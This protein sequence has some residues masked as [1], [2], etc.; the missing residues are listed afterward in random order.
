MNIEKIMTAYPAMTDIH[1]TEGETVSIRVY[2]G[3]KK[4]KET[5]DNDFFASLFHDFLGAEKEEEWE[6]RGSCDGGGTIGSCRLRIHL[7]HS[8]GRKAA[9]LRI[10]PSLA[11]LS[12]DPDREWIEKTAALEH[13]LVLVTGPSGSG[14][15]TTLARILSTINSRR[16]CH[17]VTLEDPVEYVIPSDKALVHQREVG[18]D[19]PDFASGVRDALREDPDVIALGEMRDS[20]TISAALTAAETGHLVLGTLHTTRAADSIGRI[21]H[22]FPA[23]RQ[24]EIRSLLSATLRSVSSQRLYRTGKDTFLLREILT[25][26]PATAHLIREGKEAQIPSYMEMG[27]HQMRTMKQAAYGLKGLSERERD[28]MMRILEI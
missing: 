17:M 14:K 27:L 18:A 23:D 12:P 8:F 9:A 20:E 11:D 3:L 24:E 21:I 15:S 13:G 22:A 16:P 19:V 25:N 2:G 10:L 28:K 26:I 1:V 5:A 7:Y 6:R 4:L